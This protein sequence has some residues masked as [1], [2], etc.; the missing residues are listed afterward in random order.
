[1]N[2]DQTEKKIGPSNQCGVIPI[3]FVFFTYKLAFY[4]HNAGGKKKELTKN[5]KF[6]LFF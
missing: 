2:N 5:F 6:P 1:M 3:T 4:I